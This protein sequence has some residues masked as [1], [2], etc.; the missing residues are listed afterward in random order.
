R[1]KPLSIV[2]DQYHGQRRF[3][4]ARYFPTLC[5]NLRL[6]LRLCRCQLG[7]KQPYF[8]CELHHALLYSV[9]GFEVVIGCDLIFTSTIIGIRW[10]GGVGLRGVGLWVILA[11]KRPRV[12]W[13]QSR[14]SD[15]ERDLRLRSR[16]QKKQYDE[17]RQEFHKNNPPEPLPWLY[18]H[19][20]R[21]KNRMSGPHGSSF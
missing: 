14:V 15:V 9:D 5:L 7:L 2:Q 20:S 6:D 18:F 11:R 13:L 4:W 17:G 10:F 16:G 12:V 21:H 8:L 3:C 19:R 1:F